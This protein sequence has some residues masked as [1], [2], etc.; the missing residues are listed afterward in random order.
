LR[1]RVSDVG[2]EALPAATLQLLREDL[3]VDGFD[4]RDF[5]RLG[6]PLVGL[7]REEASV[8]QLVDE[9]V[10]RDFREVRLGC[11]R[12][13]G[14][15]RR[16]SLPLA[17]GALLRSGYVLSPGAWRAAPRSGPDRP[18]LSGGSRR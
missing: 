8:V 1:F 13:L 12:L 7:G 14:R 16:D 17:V 9:V 6:P 5:D 10:V 18:D 11:A 3:G 15:D 4:R 2:R